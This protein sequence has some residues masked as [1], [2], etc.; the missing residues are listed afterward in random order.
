MLEIRHPKSS[1]SR[2]R[3]GVSL[4]MTPILHSRPNQGKKPRIQSEPLPRVPSFWLVHAARLQ[5]LGD[6]NRH[7][8]YV[9]AF[10]LSVPHARVQATSPPLVSVWT[11]DDV[12]GGSPLCCG[13]LLARTPIDCG[14]S[15]LCPYRRR[16]FCESQ[17]T[18]YPR[19]RTW[20]NLLLGQNRRLGG[21]NYKNLAVDSTRGTA[22]RAA[23]SSY[24]SNGSG[25]RS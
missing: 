6:D 25:R 16:R 4:A 13:L 9:P 22:T 2:R 17:R 19:R 20:K 14:P 12:R 8:V 7:S 23:D 3:W 18:F 10:G 15:I 1:I 5:F 24:I 11:A 21:N